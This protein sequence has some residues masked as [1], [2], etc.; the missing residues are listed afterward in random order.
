[1]EPKVREK[2]LDRPEDVEGT[3]YNAQLIDRQF[4][5]AT[6]KNDNIDRNTIQPCHS[7]LCQTRQIFDMD[8][9]I[10][11]GNTT[12]HGHNRYSCDSANI[13]YLIHC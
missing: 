10:T 3:G 8:T 5:C 1:M 13:I 2:Q 4:R 6:A 7:N 12:Y 9:T 11:C